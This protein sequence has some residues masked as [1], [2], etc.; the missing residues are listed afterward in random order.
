M[1]GYSDGTVHALAFAAKHLS[2]D[3]AVPAATLA[4]PANLAIILT[5]YGCEEATV[6]AAVL[7]E[8]IVQAPADERPVLIRRLGEK[9]GP[10]ILAVVGDTLPPQP[11]AER[12]LRKTWETECVDRLAHLATLE[13]RTLSIRAAQ[14]ILDCGTILSDVRRL[15]PEYLPTSRA[16]MGSQLVWWFRSVAETLDRHEAWPRREMLGELRL[17]TGA[18]A[19]ALGI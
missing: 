11:P 3:P 18:L 19:E 8:V 6:I 16:A 13:P 5:S 12:G 15:G 2:R 9:F 1:T 7:H 14:E 4:R 17:L 10:V